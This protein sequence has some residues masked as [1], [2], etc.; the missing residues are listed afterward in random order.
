MQSDSGSKDPDGL[1]KAISIVAMYH[2]KPE[3]LAKVEECVTVTQ[4]RETTG[5]IVGAREGGD[6]E[7]GERD[8][9]EGRERGER[10]REGRE[11]DRG[12]G[13]ERGERGGDL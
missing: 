12:E 11:R 10:E 4:V 9:G 13:R 7:R 6:R 5:R 8:R 2:G 1:V 3:L